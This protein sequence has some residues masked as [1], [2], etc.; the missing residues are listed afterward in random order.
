MQGIIFLTNFQYSYSLPENPEM[1]NGFGPLPI[2]RGNKAIFCATVVTAVSLL[3]LYFHQTYVE[4]KQN[5]GVI[6]F[7]LCMSIVA[8]FLGELLRRVCLLVEEVYHK[9]TR[10]EGNWKNVFRKVLSVKNPYV[11]LGDT[12][13]YILLLVVCYTAYH[14]YTENKTAIS[15]DGGKYLGL[16]LFLNIVTVPTFGYL[17]GI[18]S[19]A[20]VE[21]SDMNE[22]Y[23][24]N[25]ADGLA[26]SYYF[27]YLK[28]VL[29]HL[30]TQIDRSNQEFR[31]NIYPIKLLILLP[32]DCYCYKS[33]SEC[34][35]RIKS[36]GNLPPLSIN[37]AGVQ[38][39]QYHHT[40][41]KI[42]IP[43]YDQYEGEYYCLV[44]YATPLMSLYDMTKDSN[45]GFSKE[46][47]LE[48][49]KIF[50]RKLTEI[51]EGDKDCHGKYQL[52]LLADTSTRKDLATVIV[53]NIKN[54]PVDVN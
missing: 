7:F 37:R 42:T 27:G 50:V 12:A 44:E 1:N 47:C 5:H 25:L 39:R 8:M 31:E 32:K 54:S 9:E 40:V 10:Y 21:R 11:G 22:K 3:A 23:K 4:Q 13:M 14:T 6:M 35:D 18:K 34:D 45:A 43:K 28:L 16:I 52:V 17:A 26:W 41:H 33:L 46:E 49:V 36:L 24:K 48:Q 53:K 51:L 29:P 38:K 15:S 19:P 2:R 30:P 20:E